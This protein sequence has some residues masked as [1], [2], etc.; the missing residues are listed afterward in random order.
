MLTRQFW[1]LL[2]GATIASASL[3]NNQA[4]A[5]THNAGAKWAYQI[6]K[7]PAW[8]ENIL[9]VTG[10]PESPSPSGATH[11]LLSDTQV[12]LMG[13]TPA[14]FHHYKVVASERAGLEKISTLTIR[15]NP[16]F[17]TLTLHD[18]SV[19]RNGTRQDR[20]ESAR[21]NLAQ[22]ERRLEEGI[23]DE[24]VSAIIS[25]ADVRV[26]DTVEHS[27]TITGENPVFGGK[28]SSFFGLNGEQ[29]IRQLSVKIRHP[30]SRKLEHRFFNSELATR[31]IRNGKEV[32]ILVAGENL[33]PVHTEQS[34]PPWAMTY[35]MFEISEFQTWEEVSAWAGPLYRLPDDLNEDIEATLLRLKAGAKTLKQLAERILSWV[36]DDIRYYSIAIGASAHRPNHPNLT[37]KQKFGD[38]KDKSLLL[39]SMLT[40]AGIKA[41]PVLV[42]DRLRKGIAAVLPT[43]LVFDHVIVRVEVDGETHF[44]DGTRT[45]Q[46]GPLET[47]G[48]AL[49]GKAL[50]TAT[51]ATPL[52][53]VTIPGQ[54]RF[55][56]EVVETFKVSTYGAPAILTVRER[57]FGN[58]AEQ[59]RREFATNGMD[60]FTRT[61]QADYEA[62]FP[63]IS[64]AGSP[65]TDDDPSS[66]VLTVTHFFQIPK[67][68]TYEGG[69]AKMTS[70][71]AR[72]IV[73]WLKVPPTAGRKLPFSLQAYPGTFKHTI[74]IEAPR[75]VPLPSPA[76]QFWQDRHVRLSN[77]F[78]IDDKKIVIDYGL[79]MLSDHVTIGDFKVFADNL[80]QNSKFVYSN[81]SLPIVNGATYRTRLARELEK[82]RID[83]RKPD[84]ADNYYRNILGDMIVADEAISSGLLSESALAKALTDRATA[85][86]SLG[87]RQEATDDINRAIRIDPNDNAYLLRGEIEIFSGRYAESI[88]TLNRMTP[89]AQQRS[90]AQLDF[91]LANFYLGKYELARENFE[92]ALDRASSQEFPYVTIWF[93]LAS[94]RAGMDATPRVPMLPASRSNDWPS[95][96]VSLLNGSLS[97]DALIAVANSNPHERRAR[98]CEAYYF[99]GQ[100]ALAEGD[101]ISAKRWFEESVETDVIMYRE[102]ILSKNEL[103]R[104]RYL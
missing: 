26:G 36:Q 44:I 87:Y 52:L 30:A 47:R 102:H 7:P 20:L 79:E 28:Y 83:L 96:I 38:C 4:P 16:S 99:L 21:I 33:A 3:A 67:L 19:I 45:Y 10:K 22:R 65:T 24:D 41:E 17:E 69:R 50:P 63:G 77:A 94:K 25:L 62:N 29:F 76:P 104:M 31:E 13:E 43:P 15:F 11:I 101:P 70:T 34:V 9:P 78:T 59:T 82:T 55:G 74:V 64:K 92:A 40:R 58:Y 72:S 61:L 97:T 98:L 46:R 35:P 2:I 93:S 68:F 56:S 42:S 6:A 32:V 66:N 85:R 95:A 18:I 39:A 51:S 53:D 75:G 73:P 103:K 88:E 14:T 60:K 37:I 23:Y 90:N 86:S 100:K 57:Y 48:F 8:V 81:V 12:N 27:F 1:F 84:S 49:Y 54:T 91:G 71:Y 89:D 5:T 80:R